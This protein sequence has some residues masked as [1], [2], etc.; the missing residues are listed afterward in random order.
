MHGDAAAAIL[1]PTLGV[2]PSFLQAAL[3]QVIASYGS[4]DAYLTQGLGRSRADIYVLRAKLVDFQ[5]LPGQSGLTGNAAAGAALLN[6]LQNSPLS[7]AYT[8]FNYYLQSSIDAG[9]LGGVPSQVGGQVRAR[10]RNVSVAAAGVARCRR[11]T[12][13]ADG[14]DL[15]V[16]E[17][18]IWL[19]GL[20][21]YFNT[22]AHGG[23][24]SSSAQSGGPVIGATYR[25][26]TQASVFAGLGHA[27]GVVGSADANATVDT[28]LGTIGGRY[29]FGSL[30]EGPFVAMRADI[31]GVDYTSKRQLGGGLGTARGSAP[32]AIYG[33]QA[34][35]AM[36]FAWR[37]SPSHRARACVLRMSRWAA[38]KSLAASWRW[39]PSASATRVP[40]CWPAWK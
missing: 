25:V 5:M 11:L 36:R 20:G 28:L 22:N 1:A 4:M 23:A 3:D 29:A 31:G 38:F 19:T 9:T 34:V 6:A 2:Q 35:A 16:G 40:V 7:G 33:G 27:W 12:P 18:R 37:R 24:A 32:G 21:G 10:C 14:R 30:E 15:A 17:T 39:T 26:G 13:Y 8:A